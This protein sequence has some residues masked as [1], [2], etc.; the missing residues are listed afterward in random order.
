MP[1]ADALVASLG[2]G[3]LALAIV[4]LAARRRYRLCVSFFLFLWAVLVPDLLVP[5]WPERYYSRW[6]WTLKETVQ[7]ALLVIVS[8]EMAFLTF[9]AFPRA[10]VRGVACLV[11]LAGVTALVLNLQPVSRGDPYEEWLGAMTPVCYAGIIW[12]YAT[13]LLVAAYYRVPVHPF[14]RSVIL[15]FVLFLTVST[16]TLGVLGEFGRGLY[17]TVKPLGPVAFTATEGL[18]AWAAWRRWPEPESV[19]VMRR[20]QPWAAW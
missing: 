5:L 12:L 20:L 9:R 17:A 19:A 14:H 4:G 8:L 10:R 6:F 2:M 18:W 16:G 15:G 7:T 3:L 11:V 13:L 1:F